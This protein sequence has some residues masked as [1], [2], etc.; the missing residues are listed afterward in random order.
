MLS[1]PK[2]VLKSFLGHGSLETGQVGRLAE[3]HR[4]DGLLDHA[5]VT[6]GHHPAGRGP[7]EGGGDAGAGAVVVVVHHVAGEAGDLPLPSPHL[8]SQGQPA[9]AQDLSGPR[10]LQ[11]PQPL[12]VL[13][14]LL[15]EVDLQGVHGSVQVLETPGGR[16]EVGV[17]AVTV[18]AFHPALTIPD[19]LSWERGESYWS[20]E[21]PPTTHLS[22]V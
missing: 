13:R 12:D 20:R 9:P 15:D 4:T 10:L 6:Q 16:G 7:G 11:L 8:L 21:T 19:N 1:R 18:A 14:L 17:T 3:F 2:S 5:P 22:S